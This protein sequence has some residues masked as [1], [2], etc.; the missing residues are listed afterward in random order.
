[1]FKVSVGLELAVRRIRGCLFFFRFRVALMI[2]VHNQEKSPRSKGGMEHGAGVGPGNS[3][4]RFCRACQ[5]FWRSRAPASGR[6]R[7]TATCWP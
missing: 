3:E 7:A 5:A 4:V 1:M 6:S 2:E